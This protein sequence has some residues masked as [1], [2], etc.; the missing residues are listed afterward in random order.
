MDVIVDR[1]AALDVHKKTVMA[2]VRTPGRAG[3]AARRCGSSRPSPASWSAA[4]LAGGRGGDPGGDGGHRGLLEA[5]VARAGRHGRRSSCCWSTRAHV[6]NLPGPQDRR[7]GLGVVGPAARVR[8]AAGQLRP[9]G[10]DRP[11]AGPDP[12]SDQAHP[13][14][15]AGDPAHPEAAGGRRHQARLGG[16]RRAGRGRAGGCWRR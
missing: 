1:C 10:R 16:H 15:G 3:G 2:A 11:A 9:A 6:K 4:G 7:G 12:V 13:G 5:G 14:A 8:P